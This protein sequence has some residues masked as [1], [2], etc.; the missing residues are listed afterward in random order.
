VDTLTEPPIRKIQYTEAG[1][2]CKEALQKACDAGSLHL[3]EVLTDCAYIY[4]MTGNLKRAED[5]YSDASSIAKQRKD[6]YSLA[7]TEGNLAYIEHALGRRQAADT[8]YKDSLAISAHLGESEAV[9]AET[10]VRYARLLLDLGDEAKAR[11]FFKRAT[12]TMTEQAL[13]ALLVDMKQVLAKSLNGAA[14]EL[15]AAHPS[16]PVPPSTPRAQNAWQCSNEP[17]V[18][19]RPDPGVEIPSSTRAAVAQ[20]LGLTLKSCKN[21]RLPPPAF[22]ASHDE[23]Q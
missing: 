21:L 22:P 9:L 19:T 17:V 6:A 20:P 18:P 15:I 13:A 14:W 5:M 8:L 3:P 2:Y 10:H 1:Q 11:E 23:S 12:G 7:A 16:P 4:T